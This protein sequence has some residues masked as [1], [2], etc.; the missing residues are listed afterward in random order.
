MGWWKL[1]YWLG[2][3]LSSAEISALNTVAGLLLAWSATFYHHDS[4]FHGSLKWLR[5]LYDV[6]I[7]SILLSALC[8]STTSAAWL[9]FSFF[10]TSVAW[11][12]KNCR[13]LDHWSFCV[14]HRIVGVGALLVL[15]IYSWSIISYSS[16]NIV[17][18]WPLVWPRWPHMGSLWGV[19]E[20][21]G[22]WIVAS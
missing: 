8:R 14:E 17:R 21:C 19:P 18:A 10:E 20:S 2:V 4:P 7:S 11:H 1:Q 15:G 9:T 6:V 16:D 3:E 22:M 13:A 5:I 12:M